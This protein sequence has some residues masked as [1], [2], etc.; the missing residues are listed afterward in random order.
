MANLLPKICLQLKTIRKHN[1]PHW[2]L[3]YI[4]QENSKSMQSTATVLL[5]GFKSVERVCFAKLTELF[6]ENHRTKFAAKS[7]STLTFVEDI[8]HHH[9]DDKIIKFSDS[10][11]AVTVRS[12]EN[13]I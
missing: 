2:L 13:I 7:T 1:S 6:T 5:D 10:R 9:A 3:S 12:A 8:S 4:L 11:P